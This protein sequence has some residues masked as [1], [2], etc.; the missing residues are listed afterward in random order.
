MM[1]Y[2]LISKE[3]LLP[4]R[5][6]HG[7]FNFSVMLMFF[8]IA[9]FGLVIRRARQKG[10]P[11]PIEAIKRHRKL[12]PIL[13][14]LGTLGFGAGITLVLLDTG[15]I[16]KYPAHLTVGV[17]IVTLLLATYL[18]SRKITGQDPSPFRQAHFYLGLAILSFYVVEVFLGL[19]VLL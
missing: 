1:E 2:P 12:G 5:L 13:A 18:I 16:L 15:D 6:G 14:I 8:Y 10:E 11:R 7:L 4:L 9:R 19:G 17:I 3:L